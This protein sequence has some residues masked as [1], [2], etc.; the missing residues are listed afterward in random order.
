MNQI[1]ASNI[2]IVERAFLYLFASAFSFIMINE[3]D[4]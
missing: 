1:M 3:D 4:L 2:I